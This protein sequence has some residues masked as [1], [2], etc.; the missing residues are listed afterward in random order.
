[1][2]NAIERVLGTALSFF[3]DLVPTFGLSIIFLTIA[4]NIILFPL[5]LK[6]T[7]STRAFQAV[8]PELKRVQK[9][10]K[11]EPEK[12]QQELM[13][14]QKEAGASPGGC[15][16]PLVVQ[17]PIW[18]GLFR[19]LSDIS[20][21]ANGVAVDEVPLAEGSALL[22]A[23]RQGETE[24]LTMDLGSTISEGIRG[25]TILEAIPYALLIVIMVASQYFQQWHAQRGANLG[26]EE[27]TDQQRQQQRTQQMITRVM[28]LFIGFISWNFPA[29]LAVYWATGNV[30]RLGQQFAIFAIDG[31]PTPPGQNGSGNGAG[32][33]AKGGAGKPPPGKEPDGLP[34]GESGPNG[35]DPGEGS[36][37]AKPHPV[38]QKKRR[39]RRR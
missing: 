10:Y 7:R 19:L 39:R 15:L 1:M 4:I 31:R 24:F 33:G 14:V 21:I 26:G 25:G 20:S 35:A 6:Q 8:Q 2:L 37:P 11:D 12:L 29:G 3:Y 9:E 13:R 36:K 32:N 22:E 17:F 38:S 27:M 5:T 23:V 28:P 30:F 18:L 34:G 16:L